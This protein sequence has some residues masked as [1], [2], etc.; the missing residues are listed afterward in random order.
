MHSDFSITIVAYDTVKSNVIVDF[1]RVQTRPI[2]RYTQFQNITFLINKTSP[3]LKRF[4]DY[5]NALLKH[6]YLHWKYEGFASMFNQIDLFIEF[7]VVSASP[8][9]RREQL[10]SLNNKES[11]WILHV[12]VFKTDGQNC[13]RK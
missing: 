2:F 6:E 4:L 9:K 8:C 12:L 3:V 1:G 5:H 10:N 13:K 11:I 7:H